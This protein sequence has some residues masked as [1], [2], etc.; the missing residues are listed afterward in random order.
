MPAA[1]INQ[2]ETDMKSAIAAVLI[3]LSFS[4]PAWADTLPGDA[5]YFETDS[6]GRGLMP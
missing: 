5:P 6:A 3:A 1:G 2:K 4:V